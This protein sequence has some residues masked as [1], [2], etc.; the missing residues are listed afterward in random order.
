MVAHLLLAKTTKGKGVSFF[1]GHGTWHHKIPNE[2]E[3]KL[4]IKELTK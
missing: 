1:E 3:L 4:I 2:N